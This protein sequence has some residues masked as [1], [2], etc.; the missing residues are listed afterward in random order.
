MSSAAELPHAVTCPQCLTEPNVQVLVCPDCGHPETP[1]VPVG[2]T[3]RYGLHTH[4]DTG[5]PCESVGGGVGNHNRAQA[6][7]RRRSS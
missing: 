6:R 2:A 7:P 5:Q 4:P 1:V 3:W